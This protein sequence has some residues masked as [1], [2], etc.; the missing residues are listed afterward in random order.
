MH[1]PHH[2]EATNIPSIITE[3]IA[4]PHNHPAASAG[5]ERSD[6]IECPVM[7]GNKV[8]RSAAEADGMYRDYK[9]TR[10][11]LCC[12]TCVALFDADPATYSK[13]L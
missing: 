9:G 1:Q 2:D 5:Q 8:I 3:D 7:P 6:L 13:A 11:Y 4:V 10:H 12:D